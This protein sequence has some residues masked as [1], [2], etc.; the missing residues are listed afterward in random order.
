MSG[1]CG[2]GV[3]GRW[4]KDEG[5]SDADSPVVARASEYLKSFQPSS[6][7]AWRDRCP[8]SLG[9]KGRELKSETEEKAPPLPAPRERSGEPGLPSPRSAAP[10]HST[11][12]CACL[13]AVCLPAN[14]TAGVQ[15][16][17]RL[18]VVLPLDTRS[19]GLPTSPG[20]P[21]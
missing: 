20:T 7:Y 19:R 3:E 8:E 11:G 9:G 16:V 5:R 4:Q 21:A 10:H 12:L 6:Y 14:Q 18:Q 13:L 1:G 2:G 17:H 15:V